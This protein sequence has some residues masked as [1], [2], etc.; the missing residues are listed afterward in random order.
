MAAAGVTLWRLRARAPER[1]FLG[2]LVWLVLLI[3][4][5]ADDSGVIGS[6][7]ALPFVVPVMLLVMVP[8]G[9]R[10][11]RPFRPARP[12]RLSC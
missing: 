7:A 3:G 9:A 10:R 4:W 2:W 6:A 8:D 5:A 12:G 11:G 1:C